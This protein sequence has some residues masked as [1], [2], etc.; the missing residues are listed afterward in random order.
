MNKLIQRERTTRIF[1]EAAAEIVKQEGFDALT[2][3]KVANFASYNSATLYNYFDNLEHLKSLC[4]L[5]FIKGYTDELDSIVKD[6]KDAYQINEAVWLLFYKHSYRNPQIFHSIFGTSV[7]KEHNS[8]MQ[9]FYKLFPDHLTV[10]SDKV[11]GMLVEENIFDRTMFLLKACA[12]EGFFKFEDL[13]SIYELLFFIYQ[14]LL[15][16]VLLYPDSITEDEFI[17]KAKIY[18]QII[19]DRYNIKH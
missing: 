15:N 7:N 10:K 17:Y 16:K 6:C 13:E 2:I 9:E 4:A 8:H 12:E 18:N 11:R 1:I 19:F 5:I 14:G 3:R